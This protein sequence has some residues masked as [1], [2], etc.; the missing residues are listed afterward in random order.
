VPDSNQL[1]ATMPYGDL[2]LLSGLLDWDMQKLQLKIMSVC[3][4]P[5]QVAWVKTWR[6]CFK[7]VDED[8][9]STISESVSELSLLYGTRQ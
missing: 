4:I 2:R 8:Q 6:K 1:S 9:Q 5:S 3:V 7:I